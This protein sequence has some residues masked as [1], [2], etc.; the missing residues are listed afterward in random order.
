MEYS[1]VQTPVVL[2]MYNRPDTTSEVLKVIRQ[3]RPQRLFVIA[4]GPRTS[5]DESS[6]A[7]VR[8]LI[9]RVDWDCTVSKNYSDTNMGLR[10]RVSSGLNW[11][12]ENAEDAIILEDDCVPHTTFFRFCDELLERYRTDTRI[13]V[14]S[15]VNHQHG[16]N[17]TPYSYYFSIYN[18]CWGWA[19]WRRAWKYYDESMSLWP[20]V[21]ENK[22]LKAI[23]NT[24]SAIAYWNQRLQATYEEKISSWA[25]RWTLSC[26]LQ[27]GL[28]ILPN[29]NLVSNIGFG[30]TATHTQ[31]QHSRYANVP[32]EAIDFPLK[33][34]PFILRHF[35][36]DQYTQQTVYRNHILAP[37]KRELKRFLVQHGMMKK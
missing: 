26:W 24:D 30:G 15:A 20:V 6:C 17:K 13:A 28:T 23:L 3:V 4:D 35:S 22:M 14:I 32:T 5:E 18:H 19:T 29:S 25:Y 21:R 8:A 27:N 36:A 34:P 33:H 10:Q 9:D 7:A 11:V 37:L 31:G 12:F 16:R 2:M 1:Q